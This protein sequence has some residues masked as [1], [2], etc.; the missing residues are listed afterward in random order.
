MWIHKHRFG[1]GTKR[2]FS[3]NT[4]WRED[5][6]ER[7][8]TRTAAGHRL[9]WF[10]WE[11]RGEGAHGGNGR[12]RS[13]LWKYFVS[14]ARVMLCPRVRRPLAASELWLRCK[15]RYT[16][17]WPQRVLDTDLATAAWGLC[18]RLHA[19]QWLNTGLNFTHSLITR[20]E[21]RA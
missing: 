16:D 11:G 7:R 1:F 9:N 10:C 8:P 5:T 14:N 2:C 19:F 13:V 20:A 12:V 17:K 6:P 15:L 3:R 4:T 21:E 18:R